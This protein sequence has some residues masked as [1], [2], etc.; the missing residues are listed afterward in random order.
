MWL[1]LILFWRRRGSST[2]SCHVLCVS[3][4]YLTF[5]LSLFSLFKKFLLNT[6]K[7]STLQN[8]NLHAKP[9]PEISQST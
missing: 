1:Q 5:L 6:S 2:S 8:P 9:K 4:L 7:S 3:P